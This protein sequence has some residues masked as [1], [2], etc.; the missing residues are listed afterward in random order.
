MRR[1]VDELVQV[2]PSST[3][4]KLSTA[5]PPYPPDQCMYSPLGKCTN[6]RTVKPNGKLH[7]LCT[8]HRERQ[9][10]NQRRRDS[11]LRRLKLIKLEARPHH[12]SNLHLPYAQ[13]LPITSWRPF[14]PK[15]PPIRSLIRLL[16]Q[17]E[18]G[19]AGVGFYHDATPTS[20]HDALHH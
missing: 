1:V 19:I 2:P 11:K 17:Q 18:D 16:R 15:L 5:K 3:T 9:N 10:A 13:D 20:R 8:Y 12:I 6:K 4:G 7:S 14:L